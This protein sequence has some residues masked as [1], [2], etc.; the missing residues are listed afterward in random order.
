MIAA[1]D[2]YL[3]T[4][5]AGREV[6]VIVHANAHDVELR[7]EVVAVVPAVGAGR[8]IAVEVDVE[9]FGLR[10]PMRREQP[11]DAA[12][13]VQPVRVFWKLQASTWP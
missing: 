4:T 9:I 13:A 7:M 12:A 10:R 3:A 2:Q 1:D 11:L 8:A 5:G 6:E